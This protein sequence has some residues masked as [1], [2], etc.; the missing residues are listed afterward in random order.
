MLDDAPTGTGVQI[1]DED[2]LAVLA[3]S[4][5]K[6]ETLLSIKGSK[7]TNGDWSISSKSAKDPNRVGSTLANAV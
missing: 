3:S 4:E 6:D 7:L 1:K 5:D 2:L